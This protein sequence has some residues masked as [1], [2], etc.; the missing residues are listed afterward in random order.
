MAE[1]WDGLIFRFK[2]PYLHANGTTVMLG[3][4]GQVSTPLVYLCVYLSVYVHNSQDGGYLGSV[5]GRYHLLWLPLG[6]APLGS[7]STNGAPA[8]FRGGIINQSYLL[9]WVGWLF[10][11]LQ[12]IWEKCKI[13]S[14]FKA[15]WD[16][17]IALLYILYCILCYIVYFLF[18]CW[19][20]PAWWEHIH[21]S[22]IVQKSYLSK[23]SVGTPRQWRFCLFLPLEWRFCLFPPCPQSVRIINRADCRRRK[24]RRPKTVTWP[25]DSV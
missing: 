25:D 22:I 6:G 2:C 15:K 11:M 3:V 13:K 21:I 19:L 20:N 16:L 24:A 8:S 14:T 18:S 9:W 5:A 7:W 23:R 1:L 17:R 4:V 10:Q 12:M